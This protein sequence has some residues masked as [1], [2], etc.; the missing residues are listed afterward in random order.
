[1]N[2]WQTNL[3]RCL[4]LGI[5][6][7]SLIRHLDEILLWRGKLESSKDDFS[8]VL[9]DE[10]GERVLKKKFEEFL[11]RLIVTGNSQ[12]VLFSPRL[13]KEDAK[14]RYRKLIRVFHPDRGVNEQEWLNHRAEVINLAYQDYCDSVAEMSTGS[15]SEPVEA[16]FNYRPK[17]GNGKVDEGAK[18]KIKFR[19]DVWRKWLGDSQNFQ[20]NII[21]GLAITSGLMIVFFYIS[22]RATIES[23]SNEGVVLESKINITSPLSIAPKTEMHED[24]GSMLTFPVG[25]DFLSSSNQQL[26][27]NASWLDAEGDDPMDDE[28]VEFIQ[29]ESIKIEHTLKTDTE[30]PLTAISRSAN[31]KNA[32]QQTGKEAGIVSVP[33]DL[34]KLTSQKQVK[35]AL[36]EKEEILSIKVPDHTRATQVFSNPQCKE[37][38]S[39]NDGTDFIGAEIMIAKLGVRS[40]PNE[41][42][43]ILGFVFKGVSVN[44]LN[45]NSDGSWCY[46][47]SA[48]NVDSTVEGWVSRSSFKELDP[49]HNKVLDF[50]A[51]YERRF[52][53]A[54]LLAF[55]DLYSSQARENSTHGIERIKK[56]YRRFF[57]KTMYRDLKFQ[58]IDVKSED[59]FSAVEGLIVTQLRNSPKSKWFEAKS[60]FRLVL[61]QKARQTKIVSLDWDLIEERAV[62]SPKPLH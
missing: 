43:T 35:L 38:L 2:I 22:S 62:M 8:S 44:V 4:R 9:I 40:G 45:C 39:T 47:R 18:F 51:L 16:S 57:N 36:S 14:N 20:R 34:I 28:V 15:H 32:E 29:D 53:E 17:A 49:A 27:D 60:S 46:I 52:R 11:D 5:C 33:P 3:S 42:C 26:I 10:Y 48:E 21:Y 56:D 6:D 19:P 50:L 59:D 7:S 37:S 58:V 31:S 61:R 30:L 54:D 25:S 12:T 24:E 13:T 41:E 23:V 55:M 1:M